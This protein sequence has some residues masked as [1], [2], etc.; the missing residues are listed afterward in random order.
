MSANTT[1][2]P[3]PPASSRPV[4][5][6]HLVAPLVLSPENGAGEDGSLAAGVGEPEKQER[7]SVGGTRVRDLVQLPPVARRLRRRILANAL[8][9]GAPLDD[10]AVSLVL[11]AK[12][13]SHGIPID[14]F[15]EDTVWQLLWLDVFDWCSARNQ[16][17]PDGMA[18]VLWQ[19][20]DHL[21]ATD[22]LHP[23]SDPLNILREPLLS[24]G[25][26]G[27]TGQTRKPT[28]RQKA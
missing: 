4:R 6:L 15:T 27:P 23:G 25:G 10:D 12:V 9:V 26:V 14:L 19:M 1:T 16:P 13:A 5:H 28:G 3:G 21:A 17:V 18:E 22:S 2:P 20:L 7:P 8:A 11:A 24:S